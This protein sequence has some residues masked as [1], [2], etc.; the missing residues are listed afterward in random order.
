MAKKK[1]NNN[2]LYSLRP[3]MMWVWT[4]IFLAIMGFALFG[5]GT[6]EPLKSDWGEVQHPYDS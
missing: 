2:F 1:K 5:E 3:N 6:A 4:V